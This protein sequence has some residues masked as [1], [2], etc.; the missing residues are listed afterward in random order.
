MNATPPTV[1][2]PI[3]PYPAHIEGQIPRDQLHLIP[4][5][6]S[7]GRRK[8]S[9]SIDPRN[10]LTV[11]EYKI[12]DHWIIW[13]YHSGLVH[14]TGLWKAIGNAKAD[15]VKLVESSP[16][17]EFEVRRVRGGF[18]K[19]QGT[20][21]PYAIA[22][23]LASK[24]CYKIR[25]AL[26]PLFG[27][28]F[29][30]LCLKPY[31]KGFGLL[32]LK[33]NDEDL[34]KKRTRRRRTV[35]RSK[36]QS[37]DFVDR[38]LEFQRKLLPFPSN[39]NNNCPNP[40]LNYAPPQYVNP[41]YYQ[42]PPMPQQHQPAPY[43]LPAQQQATTTSYPYHDPR[44][45]Q[46]QVQPH[47]QHMM[48]GQPQQ[49]PAPAQAPPTSFSLTNFTPPPSATSTFPAVALSPKT[50][51]LLSVL[52]AAENIDQKPVAVGASPSSYPQPP[53]QQHQQPATP[54]LSPQS[55]QRLG[56]KLP[57]ITAMSHQDQEKSMLNDPKLASHTASV[58]SLPSLRGYNMNMN[59][60]MGS[61][62]PDYN[63]NS[64][65]SYS[66]YGYQT[67]GS[68][69]PVPQSLHT[70]H[71]S[72]SS[73]SSSSS[74]SVTSP[75]SIASTTTAGGL[76]SFT[77]K[78]N[79]ALPSY[80]YISNPLYN[81]RSSSPR[82]AGINNNTSSYLPSLTVGGPVN[83]G[84]GLSINPPVSRPG[85]ISSSVPSSRPS[86]AGARCENNATIRHK[87]SIKELV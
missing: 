47:Q 5:L 28:D 73:S 48:Q 83:I 13:D 69:N 58:T 71:R 55:A 41:L 7:I 70:T 78:S 84:L 81:L 14:L 60:N 18:L 12:N 75:S 79:S 56:C 20:W 74:G 86:S 50:D 29:V 54:P 19:I 9:T 44:S 33:V 49:V 85:S 52:K 37:Y 1:N 76:S 72:V 11:F 23:Q 17:L 66:S 65:Y 77:S 61:V 31:E 67:N 22:K 62:V 24:F 30:H 45:L 27:E 6:E 53:T 15:I 57:S 64:N 34:K 8:Y 43:P 32:R 80:S 38:E 36:P 26:I 39:N 87:M 16:E 68:S 4:K 2:F 10:Y 82:D 46:P 59:M 51:R 25:Y 35:Q 42:Q 3:K 21:I 63:T 40:L